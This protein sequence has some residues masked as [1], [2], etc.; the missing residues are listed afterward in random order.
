MFNSLCY[1]LADSKIKNEG[2]LMRLKIVLF[3]LVVVVSGCGRFGASSGPVS[4]SSANSNTS[5]AKS[6]KIV[7]LSQ[8]QGKT[9]AEM[10]TI[11]GKNEKESISVSYDL[12]EAFV[13]AVFTDKTKQ[14]MVSFTL[15]TT[16]AGGKTIAGYPS[17]E[18]LGDAIG[19]TI[20]GTPT[21]TTALGEKY[22]EYMLN[23]K[24][25][26]LTVKKIAG[27]YRNA[28]LYCP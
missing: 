11:L 3:T 2:G 15:K 19:L 13:I 4:N 22:E 7:D 20:K 23:G 26:D 16:D 9:V 24:K 27:A 28:E 12:P 18:L 21:S 17:A 1:N 14:D 6:A 10:N 8:L 25:C 5:T